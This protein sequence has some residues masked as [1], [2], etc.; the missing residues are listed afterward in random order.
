MIVYAGEYRKCSLDFSADPGVKAG[1]TLTGAD[2]AITIVEKRGEAE[3][4]SIREN[5]PLLVVSGNDVVWWGDFTGVARGRYIQR[6]TARL[7]NGEL[8]KA[9]AAFVVE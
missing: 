1:A 6:G 2:L 4:P 3:V 8:A 9:E 7:S 5:D